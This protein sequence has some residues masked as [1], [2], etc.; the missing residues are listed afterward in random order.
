MV[1]KL[2]KL[3][4]GHWVMEHSMKDDLWSNNDNNIYLVQKDFKNAHVTIPD[5]PLCLPG[6]YP[7][8]CN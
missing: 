2:D 5:P 7:K 6:C 1:M 4:K 3:E 8:Q